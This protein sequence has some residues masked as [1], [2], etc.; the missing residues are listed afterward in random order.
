MRRYPDSCWPVSGVSRRVAKNSR[1]GSSGTA[2]LSSVAMV[3]AGTLSGSSWPSTDSTAM[4]PNSKEHWI[5][6]WI[7]AARAAASTSGASASGRTGRHR[8]WS[9]PPIHGSRYPANS[10]SMHAPRR[11]DMPKGPPYPHS[12]SSSPEI[13]TTGKV[14]ENSEQEV[15][16]PSLWD[17]DDL[18]HHEAVV[19]AAVRRR[20]FFQRQYAV[21]QRFQRSVGG[22]LEGIGLRPLY[23]G[24]PLLPRAAD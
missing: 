13:G 4:S 3:L 2:T 17:Q 7:P 22:Q 8:A 14:H 24:D 12:D 5:A 6:T 19:E 16:A 1:P 9:S 15:R 21:D 23:P 20:R 10:A 18:A 11:P